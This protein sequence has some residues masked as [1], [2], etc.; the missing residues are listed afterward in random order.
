[1]IYFTAK[2]SLVPFIRTG[3]K[4]QFGGPMGDSKAPKRN[5]NS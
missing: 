5:T 1:M 3:S 4:Y 2:C